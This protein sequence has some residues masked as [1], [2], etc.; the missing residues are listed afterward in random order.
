MMSIPFLDQQ[1]CFRLKDFVMIKHL[2]KLTTVNS[3]SRFFSVETCLTSDF[4]NDKFFCVCLCNVFLFRPALHSLTFCLRSKKI[5]ELTKIKI[6]RDANCKL[7]LKFRD[8]DLGLLVLANEEGRGM[9]MPGK[10]CKFKSFMEDQ[11]SVCTNKINI[12][13]LIHGKLVRDLSIFG[14]FSGVYV[15]PYFEE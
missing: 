15:L 10:H 12:I 9:S 13:S 1:I 5:A 3:A 14:T 2:T 4:D 7:K 11:T 6:I 8:L